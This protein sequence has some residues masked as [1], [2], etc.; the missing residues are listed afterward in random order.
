M[1]V[2]DVFC[3]GLLTSGCESSRNLDFVKI[4]IPRLSGSQFAAE[5]VDSRAHDGDIVRR[6]L[7]V[8]VGCEFRPL[9]WNGSRHVGG[10]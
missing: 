5:N 7:E 9:R 4:V 2:I 8:L 6:S 3:S 10:S 1:S